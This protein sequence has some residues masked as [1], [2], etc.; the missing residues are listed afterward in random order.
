MIDEVP[1]LKLHG[2]CKFTPAQ[3][4][5]MRAKMA[6]G[7]PNKVISIDYNIDKTSLTRL[8]FHKTYKGIV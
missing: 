2:L 4:R 8:K 6:A 7:V 1:T 3:V 5:E